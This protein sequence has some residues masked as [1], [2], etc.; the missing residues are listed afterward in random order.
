MNKMELREFMAVLGMAGQG[1]M[2]DG[3]FVLTEQIEIIEVE[4]VR[5]ADGTV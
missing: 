2:L 5:E 3:N 1:G 4:P